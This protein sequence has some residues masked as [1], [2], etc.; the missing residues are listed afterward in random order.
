MIISV[1]T[2]TEPNLITVSLTA[3]SAE[4]FRYPSAINAD[5]ASC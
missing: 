1:D 2:E 5:T 4:A 3:F